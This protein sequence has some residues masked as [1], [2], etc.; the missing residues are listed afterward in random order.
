[1]LLARLAQSN[2]R[3]LTAFSSHSFITV[4]IENY[5]TIVLESDNY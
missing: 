3:R 1:M 5:G 2:C 4:S